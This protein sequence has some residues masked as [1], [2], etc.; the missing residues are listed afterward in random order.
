[1]PLHILVLLKAVPVVGTERLDG[2]LRVD[3]SAN[4]EPNGND[5]Y[6]L[7]KS[8][9]LTE[10]HGGEVT[11]LSMGPPGALDATRKALA[12][13]AT[14]AVHVSDP[15]IAG[16]DL[17]ATARILAAAVKKTE[18]D[19]LLAGFDSSDGAAGVIPSML[20][21]LLGLPYLSNAAD[22]EPAGDGR[23]RV[24]RLS[25]V[26][27]DVIEA[28]TPALI[29]GTQLLGAPRYPSLR[30]IMQ[31]R[32]KEVLAWDLAELGIDPARVGAGAAGTKVLA[33]E[34]PPARGA[35]AVVREEPDAA[36]AR[37]V[38]FLDQRGL[39]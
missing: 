12:M 30:G 21:T 2:S 6:C 37:I 35:G 17:Q 14:R 5:E 9:Q 25:A 16:S 27:Y 3:R 1:V 15:A 34:P 8:L 4:L 22:I 29:M 23:V 18:F 7:E 36:V 33:A 19:L 10:A 26:G 31:A 13:G 24:R 38:A 20:A 28:P 32:S 11:V 39:L